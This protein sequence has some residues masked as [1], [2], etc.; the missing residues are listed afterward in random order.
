MNTKALYAVA[1]SLLI[2]TALSNCGPG[3]RSER[4]APQS[5]LVLPD[6]APDTRIGMGPAQQVAS[7]KPRPTIWKN[8][9]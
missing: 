3:D 6:P 4:R 8:L 1:G 9:G 5:S 7:E 2:L